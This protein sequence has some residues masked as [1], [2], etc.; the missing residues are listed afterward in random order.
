MEPIGATCHSQ[1]QLGGHVRC[2]DRCPDAMP[3][4]SVPSKRV[5]ADHPLR[6]IRDVVDRG[7]VVRVCPAVSQVGAAVECV[8]GTAARL[9][10]PVPLVRGG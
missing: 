7:G 5:P 2:D 9:Q 10:P 8:R 3:S 1:E 4:Y 6:P